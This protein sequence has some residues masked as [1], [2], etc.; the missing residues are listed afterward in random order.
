MGFKK[1]RDALQRWE[2]LKR[3]RVELHRF[4]TVLLVLVALRLG[5]EVPRPPLGR[6]HW[7]VRPVVHQV[8][9]QDPLVPTL[10]D[11][12]LVQDVVVEHQRIPT[13]RLERRKHRTRGR[14]ENAERRV[15]VDVVLTDEVRGAASVVVVEVQHERLDG[16]VVHRRVELSVAVRGEVSAWSVPAQPEVGVHAR[17]R[18]QADH[19][20][21]L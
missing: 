9:P 3:P 7:R 13:A 17:Q 18:P 16:A 5:K 15:V 6:G 11:S 20:L 1:L 19:Q 2:Q 21:A 12:T 14:S 8:G 4:G 10:D